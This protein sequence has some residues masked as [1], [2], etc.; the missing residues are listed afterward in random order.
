MVSIGE[1]L[2]AMVVTASSPDGRIHAR[3]TN[4]RRV[5]IW[6]DPGAY[7][8]YD[9]KS[10]AHQLARLG[11]LAWVAF[12]RGRSEAYR[13]ARGLSHEELAAAERP[14]DDPHR[15]RYEEEL[16]RIESEGVSATGAVRVRT[17][18]MTQWAVDIAAGTLGRLDEAA[19]IDELHSA[20]TA[21][22]RDRDIKIIAVKADYF[23]IGIPRRWRELWTQLRATGAS[24]TAGARRA[25]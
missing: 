11:A 1:H 2:N 12:S 19:F 23:D 22:V 5:R 20:V 9:E 10:L 15:R 18:G 7:H 24:T 25:N 4:D 16:H 3:V 14:T 6:F 17:R 13:L 21:L 8:G